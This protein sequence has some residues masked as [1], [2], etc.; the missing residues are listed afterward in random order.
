M[1]PPHGSLSRRML[2]R[3]KKKKKEG[4]ESNGTYLSFSGWPYFRASSLA[5][6]RG[7]V[8]SG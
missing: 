7:L 4:Q 8:S 1:I 6:A 5:I 3:D 2:K